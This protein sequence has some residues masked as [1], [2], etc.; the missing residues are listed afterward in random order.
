MKKLVF[1]IA[2]FTSSLLSTAQK[3]SEVIAHLNAVKEINDGFAALW[4]EKGASVSISNI[5][6]NTFQEIITAN[7][8]TIAKLE[9]LEQVYWDEDLLKSILES[10]KT[11]KKIIETDK[12][13]ILT[14]LDKTKFLEEDLLSASVF[15]MSLNEKILSGNKK[16][17]IIQKFLAAKYNFELQEIEFNVKADQH[18]KKSQFYN[19][20]T[21]LQL[22]TAV[23]VKRFLNNSTQ[24]NY[25]SALKGVVDG[26]AKL[27]D[28]AVVK[29][30]ENI[31]QNMESYLN[32]FYGF[33]KKY[34]ADCISFHALDK[35]NID[36]TSKEQVTQ[37]NALV[38]KRNEAS[39]CY[40][41]AAPFIEK[42]NSL[43]LEFIQK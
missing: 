3:T 40:N 5:S 6:A 42:H 25:A 23:Q 4:M 41:E 9:N 22:S 2:L 26:L 37:F 35:N 34:G 32:H 39:K 21:I 28:I 31:N 30:G 11:V 7:Q 20:L 27:D 1:L 29:E 38:E 36:S 17:K 13:I 15:L 10:H 14:Y 24:E 16:I 18:M 8:A 43:G 33:L 12:K 19:Q